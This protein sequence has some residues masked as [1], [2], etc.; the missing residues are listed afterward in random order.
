MLAVVYFP[1]LLELVGGTTVVETE[2][3][4]WDLLGVFTGGYQEVKGY[5]IMEEVRTAV[6]AIVGFYFGQATIGRR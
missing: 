3:A 2:R 4:P 5:L 1:L 6:L